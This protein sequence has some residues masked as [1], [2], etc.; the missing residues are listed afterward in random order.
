LRIFGEKASSHPS[1]EHTPKIAS[2]NLSKSTTRN[3]I[4]FSRCYVSR[5]TSACPAKG[6]QLRCA[7]LAPALA[8]R[9]LE[10]RIQM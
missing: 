3:A 10:E 9:T 4:F 2:L 6:A 8:L 7:P 5:E 1:F